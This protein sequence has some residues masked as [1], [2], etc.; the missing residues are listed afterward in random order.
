MTTVAKYPLYD[1]FPG[2]EERLPRLDLCR[3]PSPVR[4][5]SALEEHL[6]R[7]G[8]W[9]KND[10]LLGTVYGG[11]K[12]R[13]LELILADVLDRDASTVLTFGGSGSHHCLA[14]ALYARE[15]GIRVATVLLEQ[16]ETQE[17]RTILRLLESTG[18]RMVRA[19]SLPSAVARVVWLATR[20]TEIGF[21]PRPPYML[22][23][24]ASTPLGCLGYVNAAFELA[25]QVQE[26]LLPA[27]KTVL[28]PLGSNGTAAGLLLGLRLAGLAASVTAVQVS[29]YPTVGASGVARLATRGARLLRRR[30]AP[31]PPLV[32]G[33]Q[34]L[35]VISDTRTRRYGHP[36]PA[37]EKAKELLQRLEDLTLDST[38]TA[39]AV[40]ALIAQRDLPRPLLYWHTLNAHPLPDSF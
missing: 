1:R 15:L 30:G 3:G 36:T 14:T 6:D 31:V 11:N 26:G 20:C 27:P 34:N 19:G 25:E 9:V 37:A 7:P 16:P 13:K 22:W 17:V 40:A 23:S 4:R 2:L 29:D 21:P 33:P 38:Y 35:K 24:G 32:F 8:L 5:L 10:G 39:K 28:V 18:A 12:V